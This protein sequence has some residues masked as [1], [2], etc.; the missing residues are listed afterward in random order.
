MH[1]KAKNKI[2]NLL[3]IFAFFL[4]FVLLTYG[5]ARAFSVKNRFT[6]N[7]EPT[8]TYTRPVFILDAG[9]G[10]MDGGAVGADGT[11]EKDLNLSITRHIDTILRSAGVKTILTRDTD[12][13]LSLGDSKRKKMQDLR[14][15]LNFAKANPGAIF[16]SV[17]MNNFTQS[18]YSGLQVYY[19]PNSTGSELLAVTV[20]N[21]TKLYL[22]PQNDRLC[23]PAN[24]AIYLMH[25]M[26][27]IGVLVEC[28]FLSNENE[29][30]LLKT[31]AYQKQ[32]AFVLS[33][34]LLE[35]ANHST[36][37]LE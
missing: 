7:A 21:F 23:K 2:L 35:Y 25:R 34:S 37:S 4:I 29:L 18:K 30:A 11:L 32:L 24:S 5:V 20:Q 28:G 13:M 15:R 8:A 1:V 22:Q 27:N 12:E 9:H 3:Q 33:C 31:D 16:V 36:S 6:S 14:A 17:H 26:E 19:S 10:G